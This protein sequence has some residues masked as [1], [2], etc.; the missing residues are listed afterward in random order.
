[1]H[2]LLWDAHEDHERTARRELGFPPILARLECA[3]RFSGWRAFS[4]SGRLLHRLH[5][6]KQSDGESEDFQEFHQMIT[7]A[8]R[9]ESRRLQDPQGDFRPMPACCRRSAESIEK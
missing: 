3:C 8:N 1:M 7:D 4:M 5:A 9:D 2:G 6:G